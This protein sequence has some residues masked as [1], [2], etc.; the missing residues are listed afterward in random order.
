MVK[1]IVIRPLI[2]NKKIHPVNT[3]LSFDSKDEK[4]CALLKSLLDRKLVILKEDFDKFLKEARKAITEEEIAQR[5]IEGIL[6]TP[7]PQRTP[8]KEV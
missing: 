8:P 2:H 1:A 5:A 4:S 3:E 7:L 6:G